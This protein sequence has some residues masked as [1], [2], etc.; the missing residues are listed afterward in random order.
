M[1]PRAISSETRAAISQMLFS[2]A[3]R[4]QLAAMS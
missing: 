2:S 1:M 3:A 4:T